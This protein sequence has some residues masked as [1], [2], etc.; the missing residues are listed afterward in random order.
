[1]RSEKSDGHRLNL[2]RPG[3][4]DNRT[5]HSSPKVAH[6]KKASVSEPIHRVQLKEL[7]QNLKLPLTKQNLSALSFAVHLQIPLQRETIESCIRGAI[8]LPQQIQE[9][10]I[11]S[12]LLAFSK[13]LHLSET[14]LAEMAHLISTYRTTE[15]Q[16]RGEQE[17]EPAVHQPEDHCKAEPDETEEKIPLHPQETAQYFHGAHNKHPTLNLLN[18]LSDGNKRRHIIIPFQFQE[19]SFSM[20]GTLRLLCVDTPGGILEVHQLSLEVATQRRHWYVQGSK[21]KAGGL[22]TKIH[23]YPPP[24]NP[25]EVI[26]SLKTISDTVVISFEKT[27]SFSE[28]RETLYTSFEI[29]A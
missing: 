19:K 26:N 29:K 15:P 3:P 14:A 9:A 28:F 27:E 10:G 1:M 7:A 23:V 25:D 6:S 16:D 22:A 5:S 11:L 20:K 13:G 18:R 17:K 4:S 2:V 21:N 24:Q 8:K 12:A